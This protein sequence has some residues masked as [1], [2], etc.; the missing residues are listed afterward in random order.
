[1]SRSPSILSVF[2]LEANKYG[3]MEEYALFLS[4]ELKVR[5]WRNVLVFVR[6]VSPEI[7]KM[8]TEAGATVEVMPAGGQPACYRSLIRVLRRY[9]ADL[10]H[11]HFLEHYSL[12]PIL[13]W[14]CGS[15]VQIFTDHFRQPQAVG[16]V[17]KTECL[18]WDRV[19]FRALGVRIIAISEHIKKTLVGCYGMRPERVTV[20]LNGINVERFS[21]GDAGLRARVRA[22]LGLSEDAPLVVCASN[23]RPEKGIHYLVEA[24]EIVKSRQPEAHFAIIGAGTELQRL[25]QDAAARSLQGTVQF[26]GARSD[27][28]RFMA[29]ADVIAVPSVWQEPAGFVAM[30]GMAAGRPVVATRVGGIPEYLEEGVTGLL[31]PPRSAGELAGALLRLLQEPGVADAMGRAGRARAENRFSMQRWVQD[32]LQT[33]AAALGVEG[34]GT[35]REEAGGPDE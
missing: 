21:P 7:L 9:R 31:V 16:V 34:S 19:I 30:E 18:V 32:T 8:L 15:R 26:T 11:Y 24:A 3:S 22:E 1:M 2:D 17:T 20:I 13:G 33:Y 14:W 29:A 27:V 5:G 6:S 10:V 35:K 25:R 12:L 28:H 4:A 23:L